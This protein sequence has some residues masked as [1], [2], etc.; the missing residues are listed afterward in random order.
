MRHFTS[1]LHFGHANI[2]KY[3]GRPYDSVEEMNEA[4]VANWNDQVLPDDDVWILGDLC[5]GRLP[6]TLGY[7][8]RLNGH[9]TLL[10]GNHDACWKGNGG[11]NKWVTRYVLAGLDEVVN[12]KT[13]ELDVGGNTVLL[14]HFP[15]FGDHYAERYS[16][17]R[18]VD[19]GMSLLHGH[20]HEKWKVNG[21]QINVG[22]DVWDY[23]PVAEEELL[24][25]L[26]R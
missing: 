4:L 9:K 8:G 22:I 23:R 1:D 5:L 2:I 13:V 26:R 12:K 6:D 7:I 19:R 20:I 11:Y 18:P 15:Y 24:P 25:F 10:T 14:C 3:S 17:Y 16:E 21:H